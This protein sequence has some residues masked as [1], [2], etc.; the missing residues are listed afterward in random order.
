M[1][2]DLRKFMADAKQL[3]WEYAG[4]DGKNH[5]RMRHPGIARVMSVSG[6]PSDHRSR[7]NELSRLRRIAEG[8]QR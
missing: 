2:G 3:G 6:T 5:L 1:S 7:K 4:R 8:K